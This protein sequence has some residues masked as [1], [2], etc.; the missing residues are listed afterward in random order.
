MS[1]PDDDN[2]KVEMPPPCESC[3]GPSHGSTT[4]QLNCYSRV[5]RQ[6]RRAWRFLLHRPAG[7]SDEAFEARGG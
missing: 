1:A 2:F 3:G 4:D 7:E 5:L 6:E